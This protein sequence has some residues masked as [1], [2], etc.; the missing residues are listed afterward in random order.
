MIKYRTKGMKIEARDVHRETAKTVFIQGYV[1]DTFEDA[2]QF[3]IDDAQ[4][5]IDRLRVQI[6]YVE[7]KLEKIKAM[8]EK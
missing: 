1:H 7:N 6:E 3:L 2:Q 8:K 5:E 4:S